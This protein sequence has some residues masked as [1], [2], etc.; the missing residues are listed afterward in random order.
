MPV[1]FDRSVWISLMQVP[2]KSNTKIKPLIFS[3]T[4][5]VRAGHW[6]FLIRKGHMFRIQYTDSIQDR[7]L[8]HQIR[9]RLTDCMKMQY[10]CGDLTGV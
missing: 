8:H 3:G 2:K 9:F 5:R 1:W 6:C 4:C 10:H 7:C